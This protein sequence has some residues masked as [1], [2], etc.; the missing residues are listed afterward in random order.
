MRRTPVL[1]LIWGLMFVLLLWGCTSEQGEGA[2][3]FILTVRLASEPD[4]LNPTHSRSTYATPIEGLIMYPLAEADPYTFELTPLIVKSLARTEQI[5]GGPHDGGMIFH[6]E[7]RDEAQWDDGTPVTGHDYAFTVKVALNPLVD[8]AAWRGFLSFIKDV[9]IDPEDPRKF[10]VTVP[11]P[12][13]LAEVVTCNFNILPKHVYDPD[14]FLDDVALSDLAVEET[15]A[16]LAESDSNLTRFAEA[17]ASGG[18]N[19]DTV[20]GCGPYRLVEWETGQHLILERKDNWWGDRVADKP[21]LMEAYPQRIVYRI[22][23][24]ETSA[25]SALKDG[26]V[27]FMAE[28]SPRNFLDMQADSQWAERFAFH[29]PAV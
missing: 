3:D 19:R 28:V 11:E 16:S 5:V 6:Y 18:F 21:R 25:L 1:T 20:Q 10:S 13:M 8:A 12:Y 7:I 29:S 27:D 2:R 9:T 24:D 17:F 15:A 4:N 14:G 26:T 22:I 23:P